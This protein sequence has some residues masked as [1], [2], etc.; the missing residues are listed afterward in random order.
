MNKFSIVTTIK[1]R[2]INKKKFLGRERDKI[3][4]ITSWQTNI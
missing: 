3:K 4:G 2:K 1:K